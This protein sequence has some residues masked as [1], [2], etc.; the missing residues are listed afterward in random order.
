[1]YEYI[2]AELANINPSPDL[3][4]GCRH[5]EKN[6]KGRDFVVGDLHGCIELLKTKMQQVNFDTTKDRVFSVG[7]LVDRGP[8]SLKTF[9]LID[10]PWFFCTLSNHEAMLLNYLGLYHS[11][12]HRPMDFIGNGG[13]WLEQEMNEADNRALVVHLVKKALQTPLYIS[14]DGDIPF[15]IAH[16]EL[17]V[18]NQQELKQ[19]VD[20]W[21]PRG[22]GDNPVWARGNIHQLQ[23]ENAV[24]MDIDKYPCVIDTLCP[25]D[26]D[27][28]LTYVGHT[29]VKKICVRNSHIYID[30][31]AYQKVIKGNP[32]FDMTFLEHQRFA[33]QLLKATHELT[34]T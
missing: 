24:E 3:L 27:I 19:M 14:V 29:I 8:H 32:N 7:D 6:K 11:N 34:K 33:E 22:Y 20:K 17:Q 12:Y 25:L 15:N 10:E 9:A 18:D 30:Q 21:L 26:K 1:M 5:F 4:K 31:G 23:M 16:G 28:D 13:V 2:E